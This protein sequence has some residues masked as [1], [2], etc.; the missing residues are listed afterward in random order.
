MDRITGID[1]MQIFS[2]FWQVLNL[3]GLI[4]IGYFLYMLFKLVRH[5]YKRIKK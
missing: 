2:I 5:H 1:G 4:I 3:V